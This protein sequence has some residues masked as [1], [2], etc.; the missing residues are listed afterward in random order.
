MLCQNWSKL[1][2]YYFFL[3]IAF[4]SR[5]AIKL[6]YYAFFL[7]MQGFNADLHPG[8]LHP[9]YWGC[10]CCKLTKDMTDVI[11]IQTF[12]SQDAHRFLPLPT[13][14]HYFI[15]DCNRI[16]QMATAKFPFVTYFRWQ[17]PKHTQT[18]IF[19]ELLISAVNLMLKAGLLLIIKV[20]T[21]YK[22]SKPLKTLKGSGFHNEASLCCLAL[23][24]YFIVKDEGLVTEPLWGT[25]RSQWL[26]CLLGNSSGIGEEFLGTLKN[27]NVILSAVVIDLNEMR[28]PLQVMVELEK[29][30]W[31]DIFKIVFVLF[32]LC[33]KECFFLSIS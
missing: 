5:K 22:K 17:N 6:A 12:I 9:L 29:W 14:V 2:R 28:V 23:I 16:N 4:L 13:F 1:C 18:A 30:Q 11:C 26:A 20:F 33:W 10:R 3:H 21:E 15:A 8:K 31:I 27:T 24:R 7:K 32:H 19:V 25:H